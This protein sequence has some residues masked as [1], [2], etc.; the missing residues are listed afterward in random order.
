VPTRDGERTADIPTADELVA[1][2]AALRPR[3]L[4]LQ[5]E[6]EA[7]AMYPPEIHEAFHEAGFYRLFLPR[8]YGGLEVDLPTFSR[9]ITEV[10]RGCPSSAWCLC[11]GSGHTLQVASWFGQEAQDELF[12]EPHFVAAAVAA[13][14]GVARPRDGGWA[15]EGTHRYCSGVPFS[16]HYMGQTLAAGPDPEGPPGPMLLFV[17]PRSE[18][19]MLDDWGDTL[20]LKGSGSHSLT[21]H[22]DAWVPDRFVLENTMMIDVNVD[23]GTPGSRLHGNH[24]YAGRALGFFALEMGAMVVGMAQGGLDELEASLRTRKTQRPPIVPRY[25]D[26]DYQR[27]FGTALGRVEAA[28]AL[29]LQ[30]AE[31]WM[32]VCRRSVEEG[33]P[34]SRQEDLRLN[35]MAREV[36]RLAWDTMQELIF[37]IGGSSLARN[38][39]RMERIWRDMSMT[40]SHFH[41]ILGD[42]AARELAREYFG[43]GS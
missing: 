34:F 2:A 22:D 8:R 43:V 23:G 17:A 29:Q 25:L 11:L 28:A 31:E 21:F 15:L 36:L 30:T 40:W 6:T 3:L 38:G 41:S 19:T 1:R 33:V 20:G 35:I 4:E 26:P 18:W 32:E 9:I 13:P 10:A 24:V 14:V 37:K 7:R 12:R 39:E 5:A 16:T 42:W 27:W